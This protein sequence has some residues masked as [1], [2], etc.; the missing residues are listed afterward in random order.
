MGNVG[1]YLI[2][3]TKIGTRNEIRPNTKR[4]YYYNY[5]QSKGV[6]R[7][8]I[9]IYKCLY[10]CLMRSRVLLFLLLLSS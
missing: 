4:F 9:K 5:R 8:V 6:N 1:M 3:Y 10:K 7:D 2:F